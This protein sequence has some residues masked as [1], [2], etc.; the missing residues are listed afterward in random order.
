MG[1]P[2]ICFGEK[3]FLFPREFR[4]LI[5]LLYMFTSRHD[6][7]PGR[8]SYGERTTDL[9]PHNVVGIDIVLQHMLHRMSIE[10]GRDVL[11]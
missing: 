10:L 7:H 5:S 11:C 8:R 4:Q 2:S 1:C 9:I 6:W 3:V